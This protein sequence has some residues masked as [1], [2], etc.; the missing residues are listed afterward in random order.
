MQ[1]K[2]SSSAM[3]KRKEIR[4]DNGK[5]RSNFYQFSERFTL[6]EQWNLQLNYIRNLKKMLLFHNFQLEENDCNITVVLFVQFW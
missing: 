5:I 1:A 3:M 2:Q 6:W 4:L